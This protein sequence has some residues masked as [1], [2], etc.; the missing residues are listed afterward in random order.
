MANGAEQPVTCSASQGM[1]IACGPH[2]ILGSGGEGRCVR[3]KAGGLLARVRRLGSCWTR[4][5]ASS[6][7]CPSRLSLV[8]QQHLVVYLLP[9]LTASLLVKSAG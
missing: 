7:R 1:S 2:E 3:D 9:L 5:L 8:L 4:K 6:R